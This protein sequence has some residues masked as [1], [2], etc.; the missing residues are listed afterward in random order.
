MVFGERGLNPL[1]GKIAWY[2]RSLS[3]TVQFAAYGSSS[4]RGLIEPWGCE[5]TTEGL[6]KFFDILSQVGLRVWHES[7]HHISMQCLILELNSLSEILAFHLLFT[8]SV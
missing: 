4:A 6:R 2:L 8:N 7:A 3:S 5:G 1:Y